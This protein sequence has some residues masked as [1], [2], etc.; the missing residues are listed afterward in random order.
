M[1]GVPRSTSCRE[2][3]QRRVKC[4]RARPECA[5][6][7]ARG[8]RCPGYHRGLK[9]Y[10]RTTPQGDFTDA[11]E[12]DRLQEAK[13]RG[14]VLA[15][16][17]RP[18]IDENIAPGLAGR[19]LDSQTKQVFEYVV[20]ATFPLTFCSFA[21]R[22]EPNWVDFIRHHQAAQSAP[23]EK[24]IRCLNGW[25]LG[26][27]NK[28]QEVIDKTRYMYGGALRCLAGLVE[29]PRTRASDITLATA[30]ILTVFEMIDP[31]TPRSWLLHS[32]GVAALFQ[33]RGAWAHHS[34]LAR[35]LFVT[36][37][38]FLIA[39]AFLRQEPSFLE[40]PE[41]RAANKEATILEERAGKGSWL[42]EIIERAFN[43]IS[44][45]PGFLSRT[46]AILREGSVDASRDELMSRIQDSRSIL[47]NLQRQLTSASGSEAKPDVEV[48]SPDG[49]PLNE[50]GCY[51]ILGRWLQA[52]CSGLALLDQLL[53]LLEADKKREPG[54]TTDTWAGKTSVSSAVMEAP[55]SAEDRPLDWLDDVALSMGTLAISKG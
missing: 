48:P 6:C 34:G 8:L 22:V 37:R 20:M 47:Q 26:V 29:D 50:Q 28:D 31:V 2:C 39:D 25:Y 44:L 51:T 17:G 27:K 7:L 54:R 5:R 41:W 55:F 49:T 40:K 11:R 1:V 15:I 38:S 46:T 42:N 24:A 43:E 12:F 3:L 52:L 16:V 45:G 33:L 21:P 32:R 18:S 36:I 4:D 9:F 53:V 30:I 10:N 19:A 23:I 14:S 35:T 13:D